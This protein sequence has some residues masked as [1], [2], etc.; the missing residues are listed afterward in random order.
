MASRRWE[1]ALAGF[2][3]GLGNYGML[4]F[5]QSM[6]DDS[7]RHMDERQA[8]NADA[9]ADRQD[10]SA[11]RQFAA[12][13]EGKV[14][15]GEYTPEQ[16]AAMLSR[17]VGEA[18][19]P[20]TFESSRPSARRRMDKAVGGRISTASKP[21]DVPSDDEI[22][23]AGRT[24]DL[25]DPIEWP[26]PGGQVE[27]ADPFIEF[28]PEVRE[29]A[30]V[31]GA[32]RRVLES[33]PTEKITGKD[34]T[35]AD[36]TQLV[37]R[38]ALAAPFKTSPNAVEQGTLKGEGVK[39]ELAVSGDAQAAQK[40][41][42]AKAVQGV[43][44]SPSAV[45]ARV[46][47][48]GRKRSAEL[49][50]ELAQTGLSPQ[51]QSAALQLSDDFYNQSKDYFSVASSFQNIATMAQ[52]I[53]Q[54]R[55]AGSDS[56]AS[57]IG[58]VFNFMKMQDPQSTVREGEQAQ[59]ANAGGVSD[60]VRNLYNRLLLGGR[61]SDEQVKDFS[62]T[63]KKLYEEQL[64]NQQGRVKDFSDRAVQFGVPPAI[65]VREPDPHIGETEAERILRE[66]RGSR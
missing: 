25:S 15:S 58:M 32:R 57:H 8:K 29:T 65:V 38:G 33:A 35:G 31:A 51:Q 40:A 24:A 14:A 43:E 34:A 23:Q 36:F 53:N 44:Q 22:L 63:A 26:F 18:V 11:L 60:R 10:A 48:A 52:R 5:R 49:A 54:S 27:I 47:E 66:R 21:E 6:Q 2:G 56:P 28:K 59:A 20:D 55:K 3:E 64:K 13:V 42:E 46:S 41:N 16:A 9:I 39:A 1:R 61:L 37:T 7:Q 50:A 12:E 19:A 17:R 45:D 4:K 62:Q 30:K